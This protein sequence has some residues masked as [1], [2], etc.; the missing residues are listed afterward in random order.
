MSNDIDRTVTECIDGQFER[1][2]VMCRETGVSYTAKWVETG[3]TGFRGV[4]TTTFS[5]VK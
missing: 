4:Q 5:I 1:F 2:F 3:Q